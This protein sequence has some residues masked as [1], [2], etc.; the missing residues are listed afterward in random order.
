MGVTRIHSSQDV[1]EA[2]RRLAQLHHPDTNKDGDH[3]K[4]VIIKHAYDEIMLEL[5][6]PSYK[7]SDTSAPADPV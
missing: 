4:F 3:Q 5:D 2:F 7:S 6:G 1:K